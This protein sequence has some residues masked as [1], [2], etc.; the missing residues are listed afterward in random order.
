[1]EA[2]GANQPDPFLLYTG[3]KKLLQDDLYGATPDV[4]GQWRQGKAGIVK[5]DRYAAAGAYEV[6][7]GQ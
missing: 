6:G 2:D 1:M 7:K 3:P 5:G 4:P